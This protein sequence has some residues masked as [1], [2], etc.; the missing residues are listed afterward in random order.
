MTPTAK[1]P[2][3]L[4]GDV[5]IWESHAILRYIATCEKASKLYPEDPARRSQV[6]R[7]MD[8][9][10]ASLNPVFL[11]GFRDAKKPEAERGADTGKNLAAELKIL[12][13]QLGKAPFIAGKDLTL[14]DMTLGPV[15]RRCV[16]MPFGL[17]AFPNVAA[18]LERLNAR[19]SFTKATAAG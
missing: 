4:D 14:A 5:S 18:W 8:W 9:M 1:V 6:D 3:L 10:L 12:D 16:A 7:W 13:D 15:V 2:T 17:P 11:A 19:A